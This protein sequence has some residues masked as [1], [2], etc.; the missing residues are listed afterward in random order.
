MRNTMFCEKSTA[1]SSGVSFKMGGFVGVLLNSWP[2][3]HVGQDFCRL[4]AHSMVLNYSLPVVN[5]PGQRRPG[6]IEVLNGGQKIEHIFLF[7]F[8]M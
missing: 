7:D 8:L 6:T 3:P 2:L 5:T 1:F 4:P